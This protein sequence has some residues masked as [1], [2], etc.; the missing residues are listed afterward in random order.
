MPH[1]CEVLLHPFGV[2]FSLGKYA[3]IVVQ[4]ITLT[5]DHIAYYPAPR[6]PDSVRSF[7]PS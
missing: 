4:P 7:G 6:K 1:S 5:Q 2:R 3:S